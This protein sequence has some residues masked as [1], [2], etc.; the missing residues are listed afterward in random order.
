MVRALLKGRKS[1]TRRLAHRIITIKNAALDVPTPPGLTFGQRERM[2]P[3]QRVAVGD[4]LWVRENWRVNCAGTD[5]TTIVYRA[6]EGSG[7]TACTNQFPTTDL[8]KM[9]KLCRRNGYLPSIHMLRCFSRLTLTVTA[10]KIERLQEISE[11]DAVA[12]GYPDAAVMVGGAGFWFQQLWCDLHGNLS[13]RAN[14]E[15]VALTFAVALRNIDSKE[16]A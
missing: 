14:P 4:R 6:S 1:M 10:T 8:A 15:V 9:T 7:Y 3:W 5:L 13:W 11:D 12:E 2:S 16:A